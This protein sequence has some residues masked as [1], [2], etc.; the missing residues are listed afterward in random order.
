[1]TAFP[2]PQLVKQTVADSPSDDVT[3]NLTDL[4]SPVSI[5]MIIWVNQHDC[6]D[7]EIIIKLTI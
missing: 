3:V 7:V 2:S 5:R 6:H 1:M 4:P